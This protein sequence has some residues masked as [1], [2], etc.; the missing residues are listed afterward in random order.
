MNINWEEYDK[1]NSQDRL[2]NFDSAKYH[3][4]QTN[5]IETMFPILAKSDQQLILLWLTRLINFICI[6]FN[7][8]EKKDPFWN[9]LIHNDMLDLRAIIGMMLPFI[10]D[11][12]NDDNKHSLKRLEDIYLDFDTTTLKYKYSNMQYNRAV[13]TDK[14]IIRRIF[15]K[16]YFENHMQLL[17][18][19][20]ESVANKLHVNWLD[21]L[22]VPLEESLNNKESLRGDPQERPLAGLIQRSLADGLPINNY[23]K[24][25]IYQKTVEKMKDNQ[26]ILINKYIDGRGGISYQDM[27][28]VITNHLYHEIKDYKWLIFELKMTNGNKPVINYLETIFDLDLFW[29]K[30]L[31]SQIS[32]NDRSSFTTA[33]TN[34]LKNKSNVAGYMNYYIHRYF[35]RRHSNT[36]QLE[37]DD[38][39]IC[40]VEK[41]A[42]VDAKNLTANDIDRAVKGMIN[43]PV[44]EV[45]L[46]LFNQ[47]TNF[48][49]SW[50]Y[51]MLKIKKK[52]YFERETY[53]AT[54]KN[55]Y[56]Y[57]K[58]LS[59]TQHNG[60]L[61]ILP[62]FWSSL[63]PQHCG[64]VINRIHDS[65][66]WFNISGYFRAF[67]N[68]NDQ[69]TLTK[70]NENVGIIIREN[71]I[72]I[73]FESLI[74]HG[75][76][77]EF[78]PNLFNTGVIE[79]KIVS[80]NIKPNRKSYEDQSYYFMTG[81]LYNT[82]K[83]GTKQYFD[84][85]MEDADWNFRYAMNWVSQINFYHHFAN[86][87]V[88]FLTG[89]TGTGKS[90]IVPRLLFY[91]LYMMNYKITGKIICTQPRISPTVS[92]AE[93]VSRES[94]VP[95]KEYN[96]EYKRDVPT[97]NY[98]VQYKYAADS[99]VD[100]SSQAFIRIVTDG[101][102]LN[103]IKKSPFMTKG[104][105]LDKERK[106]IKKYTAE[107]IYDI[108]IVDEAH[109]HNMNM[110]AILT[111]ARESCQINNSIKLVIISAT[112]DDDEPIYR[113]YYR[114]IND[115]RTYPLSQYI[116]ANQLDRANMDRRVDIS[117]PRRSTQYKIEDIYLS[118]EESDK[119]NVN[120]FVD[121]GI[122]LAIKVIKTT[123]QGDLLLFMTGQKDLD[124]AV[125][126]IN[127]D[128]TIPSNV[129]AFP[130]IGKDLTDEQRNFIMQIDKTIKT[131][132]RYKADV[133]LP[134]EEVKRR[135]P[136]GTYSR[137]VIVATNVAEASITL[138]NLLYVIDTGYAKVDVYY[139][140]KG[141][142][143]LITMPIS[144]TSS[145]QRKGRA[146]RKKPGTVYYL[147]AKSKVINNKTA[148]KIAD[149]NIQ[150]LLVSLLITEKDDQP[151]YFPSSEADKYTL[152][153]DYE[154]I[155]Q[156]I[157]YYYF[158]YYT[159]D[160]DVPTYY[161]YIGIKGNTDLESHDDY[162]YQGI[163]YPKRYHTGYPSS[164]LEDQSLQFYL[165]HPDENL[166]NRDPY[167]GKFKG[168][169]FSATVD[170]EY[171]YYF[172]KKN[173]IDVELVRDYK[174]INK[175]LDSYV[176]PKFDIM[177]NDAK[178]IMSIIKTPMGLI[179]TKFNEKKSKVKEVFNLNILNDPYAM[180]WF[181]YSLPYHL[182][183]DVIGM[184]SLISTF[185]SISQFAVPKMK[186]RT[187]SN[188]IASFSNNVSDL[189]AFWVVWLD[190]KQ[191]LQR[192]NLIG[193][194]FYA[195]QFQVLKD[196][197]L[198][199]RKMKPE[200]FITL[201]KM[202]T[203]GTLDTTH[204]LYHYVNDLEINVTHP[205]VVDLISKKY[206]L[207]AD[208]VKQAVENYLE[209]VAIIKKR[210]WTYDYEIKNKMKEDE[211]VN[212]I[213]EFREMFL[214]RLTT[215][216]EP[217]DLVMES[218]LRAYSPNLMIM[219]EGKYLS[220]K[221]GIPLMISSWS[222]KNKQQ[223]TFLTSNHKYLVYDHITEIDDDIMVYYLT[224]VQIEW[225]M[226]LNPV[227]FYYLLFDPDNVY[228]P[229]S[230]LR[231]YKNLEKILQ[232]IKTS[233]SM[234]KMRNYL[235]FFKDTNINGAIDS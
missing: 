80:E 161:D 179:T 160:P 76:L 118:Q 110:D 225:L 67:Y 100:T 188:F 219:S 194:S 101:L 85:I 190:I 56:N 157:I 77:S 235:R 136:P 220:I 108:I 171:Y 169:K 129:I 175:D 155:Y 174:Q 70:L 54:V 50:Y 43:V 138:E 218:Y 29:E 215:S 200:D 13:R 212:V 206:K 149:A 184:I 139:P 214:P 198:A 210:E 209:S 66:G 94:G 141:I 93:T 144:N 224:P 164:V 62:K 83:I 146:G 15:K 163:Q 232:S 121:E 204:E 63:T 64:D 162:E 103:E 104:K 38:K 7:L 181:I 21:I 167:T 130:F 78:Q 17:L 125:T 223:Q 170:P 116:A 134:E 192:F 233:F 31:W 166:I 75:L 109:E 39:L 11:N 191:I 58:L 213:D 127:S 132:T 182:E 84:W 202:F 5:L 140:L 87:R 217:F 72:N 199:G 35:C 183:E 45:Y 44:D 8:T 133:S 143:K 229:L 159:D 168:P 97:S 185:Q 115:N 226:E 195:N 173:G 6:K 227:F 26:V 9:R 4:I 124:K 203:D 150:D 82:L 96:E 57:A 65:V 91:G 151:I 135:V 89:A 19:S 24:T 222:R 228:E 196:D 16:E 178:M 145:V 10:N 40:E 208:L 128:S 53:R 46:F 61:K 207:N 231:S 122:K 105:I 14:G 102:L 51:Y 18:M 74:Y 123:T 114:N 28:N 2:I 47:L 60:K 34:L 165:I 152:L 81:E 12:A 92:N 22:P 131:Y 234:G 153:I 32:D 73:I 147:Y 55:V 148:Y 197:Y 180:L 120:N 201:N 211:D 158:S 90:T 59:S 20:V 27:Y 88:M 189:M 117:I 187:V 142:T 221:S 216:N 86:I 69:A 68:I 25:E 230:D 113:R 42:D 119:I 172:F 154:E 126:A 106:W 48:K 99:H 71:L 33:W 79:R 23:Q 1:I 95:I 98:Y 193:K 111:L 156:D 3:F 112:M 177:M 52:E 176:F 107:N 30:K 41:E 137:A 205:E 186:F 37:R 36:D 49:R